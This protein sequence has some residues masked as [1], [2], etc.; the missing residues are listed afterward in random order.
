MRIP[1]FHRCPESGFLWRY[2]KLVP[3]NIAHPV[4]YEVNHSS[5]QTGL[6]AFQ[7]VKLVALYCS[8]ILILIFWYVTSSTVHLDMW[9][10]LILAEIRCCLYVIILSILLHECMT[11]NEGKYLVNKKPDALCHKFFCYIRCWQ[12]C[13]ML[14]RQKAGL[15]LLHESICFLCGVAQ[16]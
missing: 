10:H 16:A 6:A 13:V 1:S 9:W 8:L 12:R 14:L 7:I 11:W 5:I 4:I 15:L 2:I 3:E